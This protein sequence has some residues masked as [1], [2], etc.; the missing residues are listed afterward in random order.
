MSGM[1]GRR[2]PHHR[3]S[4]GARP[5]RGETDGDGLPS[6]AR[7][8]SWRR[9]R[10]QVSVLILGLFGIVSLL[11]VGGIDVTAA[12]IARIRVLDAADA[13]ALDAAD[14]LDEPGAY[15]RGLGPAVALSTAT[16]QRAAAQNLAARPLPTGVT[17]W[18]TVVGTG[19]SDGHTAV[20]VVQGVARLPMTGG[21]LSALGGSVTITVES[22]AR[23]PLR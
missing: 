10:G 23:A 13:A 5:S 15:R 2:V 6:G 11:V 22:R 14:S 16:V 20:V 7:P 4:L 3:R 21:L 9:D 12:Q 17:S 19:T 8:P 1:P 18:G